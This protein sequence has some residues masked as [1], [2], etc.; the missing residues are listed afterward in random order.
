M[1]MKNRET[2][3]LPTKTITKPVISTTPMSAALAVARRSAE[4]FACLAVS[5]A[6]HAALINP[7][8]PSLSATDYAFAS[9]NFVTEKTGSASASCTDAQSV[10][11]PVT[12]TQV[13][14]SNT[15]SADLQTGTLR[16]VS[17]AQAYRF[18]EDNLR[19]NA[20]GFAQLYD[21]LTFEGGF[22]GDV[23][24]Q[25]TVTGSML[26]S[27]VSPLG[28]QSVASLYAFDD[29]GGQRGE[30]SVWI[31]QFTSGGA[32]IS[33]EFSFGPLLTSIVSNA[34]AGQNFDPADIEVTIS[35]IFAVTADNPTFT[36][37]ARLATS[38]LLGPF[39]GISDQLQ[40]NA[41]DFGNTAHL[42]LIVPTG[43]F[44]S[45]SSGAFLVPETPPDP[46]P[47]PGAEPSPVPEPSTVALLA[48]G[49]AML[50]PLGRWRRRNAGR[51][52][53]AV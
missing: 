25:M 11:N 20:G 42:S 9:C 3:S 34:D 32:F 21:T 33:N 50:A 22:T 8:D 2:S 10:E 1:S 24:L 37:G 17:N 35:M 13:Q 19:A 48:A 51:V 53:L 7:F 52:G 40:T 12:L 6:V 44:W 26:G 27:A 43:V 15:S 38:A 5:G 28:G 39:I 45:S 46:D 14:G 49:L 36:F 29:T 4:V 47:T 31:D 23:E 30:L 41:V 16:S 18:G